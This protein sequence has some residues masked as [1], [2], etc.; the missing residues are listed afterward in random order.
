MEEKIIHTLEVELI[1]LTQFFRPKECYPEWNPDTLVSSQQLVEFAGRLCYKSFA[2]PAG[3]TNFQYIA[4]LLEHGHLSVLEHA[5]ASFL[6][7]GIS[8]SCS[9]ELVRHRHLS[10]SQ[11]SQ[12]YVPET[13]ACFVEPEP[14]AEDPDLHAQ[15]QLTMELCRETY[16]RILKRLTDRFAGIEDPTQR[17]KLARQA[18]RCVM[19]NATETQLV[20]TGNLRAWRWF[21]HL[22]GSVHAD[23]EIRSLA[24]LIL[25]HLQQIAPAVFADFGIVTLEDGSQAV[26]SV[27]PY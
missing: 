19:P 9:H 23:R 3:R 24:L 14:I 22:R 15:F 1:G 4:N 27:Y 12:R 6:V 10:F 8:R 2:N 26:N 18:A 16:E 17:K 7:T 13:D 5:S 21:I 11:V 20:V 25:G